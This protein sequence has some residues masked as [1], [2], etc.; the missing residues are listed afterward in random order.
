M[1]DIKVVQGDMSPNRI[2]G[3][4]LPTPSPASRSSARKDL[5]F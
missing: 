4:M 3:E 1:W 2:V 5:R